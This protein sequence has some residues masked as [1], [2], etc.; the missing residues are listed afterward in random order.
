MSIANKLQPAVQ[1]TCP[2][3]PR[4]RRDGGFTLLELLMVIAI[5]AIFAAMAVPRYA[6]AAARFRADAAARRIAGDLG[7]ARGEA[8]AASQTK[9]VTFDVNSDRVSI[10]GIG[11]LDSASSPYV[12]SLGEEPYR[13]ALVSADFGGD[14]EVV[15]DGYGVPDTGGTVLVQVGQNQKKISLDGD[16][17]KASVQ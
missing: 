4:D 11:G 14:A 6:D 1:Q 12:T 17:G 8:R 13:A 2:S 7:L 3:G 10:A 5:M 9:T 16:T 15:F